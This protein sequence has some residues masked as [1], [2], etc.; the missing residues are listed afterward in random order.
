MHLTLGKTQTSTVK[1]QWHRQLIERSAAQFFS[2]T[3][4]V[5]ASGDLISC[6]KVKE[7]NRCRLWIT[8]SGEL[9]EPGDDLPNGS[10]LIGMPLKTLTW[11]SAPVCPSNFHLASITPI[12]QA[13]E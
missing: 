11:L 12:K 1:K 10:L 8:I 7:V 13:H 9:S 5:H 2:F 3:F 4:G 6:H